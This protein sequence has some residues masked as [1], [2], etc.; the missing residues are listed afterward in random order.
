[1]NLMINTIITWCSDQQNNIM[2]P[3]M[4]EANH[5]SHKVDVGSDISF[6]L[7]ME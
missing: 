4:N 2:K 1:M 5:S 3:L 6:F 7:L